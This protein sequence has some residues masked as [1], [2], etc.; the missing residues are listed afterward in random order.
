VL[1][2]LADEPVDD[3]EVG[4]GDIG[5]LVEEL[6]EE[7]LELVERK[8]KESLELMGGESKKRED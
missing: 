7:S 1:A 5:G 2:L 3:V 4:L 8:N 6:V